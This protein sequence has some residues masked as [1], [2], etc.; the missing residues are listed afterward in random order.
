MWQIT[1]TVPNNWNRYYY[2][3]NIEWGKFTI[4]PLVSSNKKVLN[5]APKFSFQLTADVQDFS[6]WNIFESDVTA[7][8]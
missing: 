7:V 4:K 8:G 5:N 3:N 6:C 1:K 2:I